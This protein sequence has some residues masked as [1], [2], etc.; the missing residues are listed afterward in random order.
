MRSSIF[1]IFALIF[2]AFMFCPASHAAV[3]ITIVGAEPGPNKTGEIPAYTGSDGLTCPAGFEKGQYLTNPYPDEKP[4]FR[5]DH[6]NV[7]EYKDRLSPGQVERLKR[8]PKFYMNIYPT[9]R[10]VEFCPEFYAAT[11]KNRE[12]A[13]V[14]DNGVLRNFN[15]GIAFPTP[16]NGLEAIWNIRRMYIA[17]DA[18]STTC[19]RIVSPSGKVIKSKQTVLM[20]N[21]G[22]A[23]LKSDNAPDSNGISQKIRNVYNEPADTAGLAFLSISYV[24]DNRL[25]DTWLYLPSLR[26]VRRS[27]SLTGGG[28]LQG[29]LTMDENGLE[30]RGKVNDWHWKLLGKKEMYVPYNT[31]DIWGVDV[32]DKEECWAKDLNPERIRYELH[33]VWVVEGTARKGLSHPYSK[34]VGYYDEDSWQP[35]VADRYDKRGNLWRMYENYAYSDYCFKY[36]MI[37]G[38]IYMNLESGRY[39]LFGGCRDEDTINTINDIGLKNSKFSVS[40]LKKDGR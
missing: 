17:D 7:D 5:I 10:T 1:S 25:E 18:E 11:E 35:L 21:Y 13:N 24:D 28:Q 38:F 31:Y 14:D 22:V 40:G 19:N 20:R 15:G 32:P 12:T 33:R 30:F 39:E 3:D 16:E 8:H 34:R 29:E 4:L 9:H 6:T 36:R 2:L 27:P 37:V 23:R 26:R